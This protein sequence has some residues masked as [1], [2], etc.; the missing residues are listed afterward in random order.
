MEL[1]AKIR[2][3]FGKKTKT[4]RKKGILPAVLYG[5]KTKSIPLEIDY[6]EFE[7]IYEKGG[8]STIIKL[9]VGDNTKNVLIHDIV[10]DPV[11]DKF[12]HADF[13]QTRMDKLITA[14]VPLIFEGE[15]PAVELEDGVLVKNITEVEIEALP[16]NLPREIKVDISVLKSFEDSIHIKDLKISQEVKIL[17]EPEEVVALVAPP[18]KEE[19]KITTP[20]EEAE[21]KV[22]EAEK[23]GE[24]TPEA[25]EGKE[26][27]KE[28]KEENGGDKSASP[29][30]GS[31][32]E[33]K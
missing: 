19:E 23:E 21:E 11:T 33:K 26:K 12:I 24:E 27:E 18:R 1:N 25:M 22:G 7:K 30:G 28:T 5:A 31:K 20:E 32:A 14:E 6:N 9:K 3:I 15:S 4:L 8:E 16:L 2:E 13:Y 29:S 17:A 10:R